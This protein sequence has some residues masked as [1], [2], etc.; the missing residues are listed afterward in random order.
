MNPERSGRDGL[1]RLVFERR[2]DATVLRRCRYTLPL[3]VLAPLT[4]DDGTSYLL[5]LNP[6]G[7]VFGGDRLRTEVTLGE[8]SRVCL[9]T[10]SATRI[11][12]TT[13]APAETETV[14]RVGSAATLEYLPDRVIPH[15][16]SSLK[17]SLRVEMADGSRGI[18]LDAFASGRAA[19]NEHWNFR[20][21]D[22]RTEVFVRGRPVYM[23]RMKIDPREFDPA[24]L[25]HMGD[26]SY[27]G[28]LLVIVDQFD[29]WRPVLAALRAEIEALPGI[30]GGVSLLTHSG[31]SVRYL[32]KSAID[33]HDATARLW[34]AA[35]QQAFKLP[36]LDL[37]KY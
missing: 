17:Q 4:L 24:S 33:F 30:F 18:F 34:T 36:A 9:S 8:K 27:S 29:A 2:G 37:R 20:D 1:L 22:S 31:C 28:S 10:P 32:A 23:H 12:R 7:G 6:T 13:D 26:Y 5:L 25:G 11:Y 19:L 16:G 35:R 14:L 15:V 3:Q 21:F